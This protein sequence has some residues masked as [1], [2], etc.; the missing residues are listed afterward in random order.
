MRTAACGVCTTDLKMI[1][2]WPRTG[3]PSIPGHEWV[4]RV[5]A[6]GA[7]VDPAW[8]GRL[9]VGEN[10]LPDGTEV[11]FEYPG[12]YAQFFVTQARALLPLPPDFSAVTAALIEPLAVAVHGL[13]RLN[14]DPPAPVLIFGDG[15]LGLLLLLALRERGCAQIALVGGFSNRLALA[16]QLGA[17]QTFDY[18]HLPED[19]LRGY[20]YLVEASGTEQGL[21]AAFEAAP[22]G[23]R[24]LV[25]GDYDEAR[26]QFA[27]NDL[28]HREIQ[29]IGSV[30]S[31]GAW[32]EAV[33][34]ATS[35]RLPLERLVTHTFPPEQYEQA[36]QLTAQGKHD[37][38][39]AVLQWP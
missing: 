16:R 23:G 9:C 17:A 39:K 7:E 5:D 24:I 27:W 29:L 22:R 4:G 38:I 21:K 35:G 12:G 33:R 3:F 15:P 1:A 13:T 32:P 19:R 26:A 34:L 2:G 25:I 28:L 20:A 30:A 36:V 37:C 8:M 14:P 6:L 31:A 10:E 11:G 18:H